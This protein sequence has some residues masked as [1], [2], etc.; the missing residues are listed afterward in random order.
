MAGPDRCNRFGSRTQPLARCTQGWREGKTRLKLPPLG[1]FSQAVKCSLGWDRRWK[2]W[3]PREPQSSNQVSVH[4]ESEY[5]P[6]IPSVH[7]CGLCFDVPISFISVEMFRISM[8]R[9][10]EVGEKS[11]GLIA[12]G[13]VKLRFYDAA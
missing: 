13:F 4:S 2:G 3:P 12:P 11:G 6:A 5:F 7:T 10:N 9:S 8:T 1:L